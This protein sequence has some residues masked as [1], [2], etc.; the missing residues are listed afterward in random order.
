MNKLTTFQTIAYQAVMDESGTAHYF[1]DT[2]FFD[3]FFSLVLSGDEDAIDVGF[4]IG[5]QASLMLKHTRGKVFGFEASKQ[6]Y[7]FASEKFAAEP[8][9]QLF[10]CAVSNQ[11]GSAEFIETSMWGA[12]SL[13][14]TQGMSHCGVGD[15]YVV[16]TVSLKRLD[17]VLSAENNIAV[18]KFDIE[19]AELLALDGGRQLLQRNRPYIVMEYCHNALSFELNGQAIKADTL[20]DFATEIGYTVYNIYGICLSNKKVWETSILKDTADVFLIPD[21]KLGHW[22]TQ[23]LPLYQYRI[24]DKMLAVMENGLPLHY[25]WLTAL[26]S[27]IYHVVNQHGE[28]EARQ[29]LQQVSKELRQKLASEQVVYETGK[30]SERA[31]VLLVLLYQGQLQQAYELAVIKQLSASQLAAFKAPLEK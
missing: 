4:N 15:D 29:Y 10:N 5:M 14:Y 24:Y 19:G 11:T 18:I 6:I 27:R 12:G 17:E 26:P 30:L 25:L 16:E 2:E 8:R 23:L 13:K 21:E 9:V 31:A 20:Y 22:N 1:N 3:E 7:D 28:T